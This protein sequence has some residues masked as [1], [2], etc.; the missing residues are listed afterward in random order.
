MVHGQTYNTSTT[1]TSPRK[2]NFRWE[3]AKFLRELPR[4]TICLR[5]IFR[6]SSAEPGEAVASVEASVTDEAWVLLSA[7]P[8]E[9]L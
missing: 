6:P 3:L 1:R 7:S 2:S 8:M 9:W 5:R 4:G